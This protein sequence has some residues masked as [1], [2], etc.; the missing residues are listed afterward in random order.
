MKTKFPA[1][2]LLAVLASGCSTHMAGHLTVQAIQGAGSLT[3]TVAVTTLKTT[4]QAAASTG[5]AV[6]TTSGSLAGSLA[7]AAFVT[8]QDTA[9][10]VS[11]QVPYQEGLRLYAASQNAKL[12]S[13]LAAFQ[14][15]RNGAPLLAANWRA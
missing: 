15:V 12:G 3:E 4:G 1:I 9:T 2:I 13:G 5:K 10:G 7:T 6:V 14:V 8:F 11:R